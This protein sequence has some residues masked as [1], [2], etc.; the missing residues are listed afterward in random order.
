MVGFKLCQRLR[1]QVGVDELE[2]TVYGEEPRPAYDRVHL[3]TPPSCP[4]LHAQV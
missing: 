3:R 4:G 1:K 2:I